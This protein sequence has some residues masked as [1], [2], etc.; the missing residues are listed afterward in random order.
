[1]SDFRK[2]RPD[3]PIY[4]S[5]GYYRKRAQTFKVPK[6]RRGI[7][8]KGQ[9][10][11][12]FVKYQDPNFIFIKAEDEA[13]K[14][15][16]LAIAQAKEQEQYRQL[17]IQDI[18]DEKVERERKE[19]ARQDELQIRRDEFAENQITQREQLR[20][21]DEA[22][23]ETQRY[24]AAKAAQTEQLR[25]ESDGREQRLLEDRR[26]VIGHLTRLAE[27]QERRAGENLEVFMRAFKAIEDRRPVDFRDIKSQEQTDLSADQRRDRRGS[28]DVDVDEVFSRAQRRQK[29]PE[30]SGEGRFLRGGGTN[31]PARFEGGATEQELAAAGGIEGQTPRGGSTSSTSSREYETPRGGSTSSRSPTPRGG[32][33]SEETE[34][35]G[36]NKGKQTIPQPEPEREE[37]TPVIGGGDWL[38]SIQLSPATKGGLTESQVDR[39]LGAIAESVKGKKYK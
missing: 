36:S 22:Q 28:A 26:E 27:A 18:E 39:D 37:G 7:K 13:R 16:E 21:Q 17:Q 9:R 24:R 30:L 10:V 19:R 2:P 1:M 15:R 5:T 4:P 3:Y 11:G 35:R 33:G 31:K 25:I 8:P 14:A 34:R 12:N 32:S 6:G 23:Q 20:L 29:S 38:K